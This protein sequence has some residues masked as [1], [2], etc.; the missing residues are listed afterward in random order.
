MDI[1]ILQYNYRSM[2]LVVIGSDVTVHKYE[3]YKLINH[4]SLFDQKIFLLACQ[5]FVK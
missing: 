5:K 2:Y 1:H 4:S 3:K